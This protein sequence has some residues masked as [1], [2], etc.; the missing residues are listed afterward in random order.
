MSKRLKIIPKSKISG[1]LKNLI[2]KDLS[3]VLNND[4]VLFGQI[5]KH[6]GTHVIFRD[7]R[8]TKHKFEVNNIQEIIIDEIVAD[9]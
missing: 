6:E 1:E 9:A 3:L 8:N 2:D 5:K 4:S 7:K